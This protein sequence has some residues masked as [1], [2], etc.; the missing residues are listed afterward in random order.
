MQINNN[1]L[2]AINVKI[3]QIINS[4]NNPDIIVK[5]LKK[6]RNHNDQRLKKSTIKR[7]LRKLGYNNIVI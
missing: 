7:I 6:I 1:L 3:N 2:N 4:T 5:K